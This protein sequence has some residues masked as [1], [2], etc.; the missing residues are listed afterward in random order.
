MRLALEEVR[1]VRHFA[2]VD[3]INSRGGELPRHHST[4]DFPGLR[5]TIAFLVCIIVGVSDTNVQASNNHCLQLIKNSRTVSTTIKDET[6]FSDTVARFC[7]EYSRSIQSGESKNYDGSYKFLK[8]SLG[9][10]RSNED[11]LAKRYCRHD[12]DKDFRRASYKRY[13]ETIAPGAYQAYLACIDSTEVSF[14]LLSPPTPSSLELVVQYRTD[15]SNASTTLSWSSPSRPNVNCIWENVEH[16]NSTTTS[17]ASNRKTRLMCTRKDVRAAPIAQP[18]HVNVVRI[19]GGK[20]DINIPWQKYNNNN[21][22]I[23]TLGDIGRQLDRKLQHMQDEIETLKSLTKVLKERS[24]IS[25]K[26]INQYFNRKWYNVKRDRKKNTCYK[27]E[28]AYP[29]EVAASTSIGKGNFCNVQLFIGKHRLVKQSDNNPDWAKVCAIVATVPPKKVYKV[30]ADGY[31]KGH[32]IL[33]SELRAVGDA[34]KKVRC[35]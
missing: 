11:V 27:N 35:P 2:R 5:S 12:R 15:D 6:D 17:L 14:S 20:G 18:D 13:L 29:I 30:S 26:R 32:I 33:W 8:L 21:E 34:V 22:P 28:S 25:K 24:Q 31:K 16:Q 7:K 23:A 10:S 3:Q 19:D 4:R 9:Q 1:L